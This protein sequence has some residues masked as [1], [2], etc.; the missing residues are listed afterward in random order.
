VFTIGVRP[1]QPEVRVIYTR[2]DCIQIHSEC[3]CL[4]DRLS[5][6]LTCLASSVLVKLFTNGLTIL[7][8]SKA[9]VF[10]TGLRHTIDVVFATCQWIKYPA[11]ND[12]TF[13]KQR[14]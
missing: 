3:G 5:I 1:I 8:C 10:W 7:N 6:R 9:A 4:G 14:K 13:L 2:R 11:F 12:I